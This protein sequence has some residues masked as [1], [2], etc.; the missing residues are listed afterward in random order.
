MG[1]EGNAIE[2]RRE[3]GEHGPLGLES[4]GGPAMRAVT[5][6]QEQVLA[7]IQN[8]P[9]FAPGALRRRFYGARGVFGPPAGF[10]G[11]KSLLGARGPG[12]G[13]DFVHSPAETGVLAQICLAPTTKRIECT[14]REKPQRKVGSDVLFSGPVQRGPRPGS[15]FHYFRPDDERVLD[16]MEQR[17]RWAVLHVAV[18]GPNDQQYLADARQSPTLADRPDAME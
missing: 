15:A 6:E 9:K 1:W 12:F 5:P 18:A 10:P 16:A 14:P 7:S 11:D 13:T 3:R 17:G 2:R 4:D 8:R